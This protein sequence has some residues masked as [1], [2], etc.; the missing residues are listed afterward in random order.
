MK[1]LA[2]VPVRSGSK[3]IVNKNIR[4]FA[5]KPLIFWVLSSLSGVS[6]VQEIIVATDGDEIAGIVES[7]GFE[8]VKIYRRD[9]ENARDESSTESVMAEYIEGQKLDDNDIFMLVQATSPFTQSTHFEQGIAIILSGEADAVLS[10]SLTKRFF[11][12]KSGEPVNYDPLNRPRRQDFEGMFVE[13]GA[14]YLSRVGNIRKY[15]NRLGGKI[16]IVEMPPYTELELDEEDDWAIGETLM[17]R[18]HHLG[19]CT[20]HISQVKLLLTDVDGVLTD[21]GMYYGEDGNELKKFN[22]YDGKAIELLRNSGV[23]IGI[24]TTEKTDLVERRAKK[25]KV[26][27]LYQGVTDKLKMAKEICEKEQLSLKQVV[28]VGDDLGDL[29]LLREVGFAFCPLNATQSIS[30]LPGIIQL[31]RKGGEGVLRELTD[32]LFI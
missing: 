25:L 2:F 29:E 11:W 16:E 30:S 12:T 31:N 7:F 13:N 6:D 17:R 32:K 23:K 22:T 5:G 3:S 26:D 9:P 20:P 8:K 15:G 28:F 27:Y 1:V 14:F 10:A 18:H 19:Q 21:A 4:P 24:L